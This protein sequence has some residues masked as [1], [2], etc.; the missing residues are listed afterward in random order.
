M[1]LA[2]NH[3]L[4]YGTDALLDTCEIL[5]QADILHTGAG[6]DLDTAKQPVLFEKNGQRVALI[7]ATR[8]IPK[9]DWRPQR[10]IPECFLLM[11]FRWSR[12]LHRLRSA[13]PQEIR[14]WF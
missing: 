1:T 14:L 12:C 5:D 8:V 2:N 9:A 10:A 13:M 3:A 4:D 6:K 7:G 11:R